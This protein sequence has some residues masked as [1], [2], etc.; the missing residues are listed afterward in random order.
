ME[1]RPASRAAKAPA[2]TLTRLVTVVEFF[3]LYADNKLIA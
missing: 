1:G 2:L 3:Y